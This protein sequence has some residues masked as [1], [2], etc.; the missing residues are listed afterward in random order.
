[1]YLW[2]RHCFVIDLTQLFRLWTEPIFDILTRLT[3]LIDRP[4]RRY[5]TNPSFCAVTLLNQLHFSSTRLLNRQHFTHNRLSTQ[6]DFSHVRGVSSNAIYLSSRGMEQPPFFNLDNIETATFLCWPRYWTGYT[7]SVTNLSNWL[8]FISYQLVELPTLSWPAYQP[9]RISTYWTH[10][11]FISINQLVETTLLL[12][13]ASY[14]TNPAF[15]RSCLWCHV[16]PVSRQGRQG[17][18]R[19]SNWSFQYYSWLWVTRL[20]FSVLSGAVC[21]PNTSLPSVPR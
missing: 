18:K 7:F 21:R 10:I 9:N 16:S 8:H 12:W 19:I 13:T 4:L 14:G 1:M 20:Y 3:L 2:I 11:T 6:H 17:L 15:S 5:W